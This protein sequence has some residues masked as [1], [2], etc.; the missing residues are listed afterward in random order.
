MDTHE[1]DVA[2]LGHILKLFIYFIVHWFFTRML[3][4]W[5]FENRRIYLMAF[6]VL[7][8]LISLASGGMIALFWNF[9]RYLVYRPVFWCAIFYRISPRWTNFFARFNEYPIR[10][11]SISLHTFV[12]SDTKCF[13]ISDSSSRTNRWKLKRYKR[14]DHWRRWTRFSSP[15]V[16]NRPLIRFSKVQIKHFQMSRIRTAKF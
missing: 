11:D 16:L 9:H 5:Y 14:F 6:P 1:K 15:N 8:T 3:A 12:E 7:E 10:A 2:I 4:I 13:K